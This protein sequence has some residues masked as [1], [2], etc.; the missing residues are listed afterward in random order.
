MLVLT[1]SDGTGLYALR[2]AAYTIEKLKKTDNNVLIL[3][4]EQKL[5][6]KQLAIA[7]NMINKLAPRAVHYSFVLIKTKE[8]KSKMSARRGEI[9]LL[10]D[11]IDEAVKKAKEEIAKRK[12]KGNAEDIAK[13]AIKYSMLRVDE[14]KNIV[15]DW[16]E[17]LNFEGESG[18]YLQ[19]SCARANSILE[20]LKKEKKNN[21]IKAKDKLSLAN[22]EIAL[23]KQLAAFKSAVHEASKQLAPHIIANYSFE[24][25]KKFNEF[26]SA[27]PVIKAKGLQKSF[28]IDIVKATIQVLGNSL[29]LLGI[30]A[31]KKM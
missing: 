23:I 8:G 11:F 15:F 19:Y 10:S 24:L 6:F 12:S 21:K 3:G 16:Q 28:R 5:Y 18:P 20:K 26:Y 27:C 25:A 9:V 13:A 29:N 17:A 2:D 22:E 1:R 7:L 31:I 4:E 30:P 14:N